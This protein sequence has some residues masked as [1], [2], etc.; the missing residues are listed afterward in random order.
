MPREYRAGKRATATADTRARILDVARALLP[1]AEDI[2][3][4]TIASRAEVSVQTLYTHF[5]SKRGLLI[6][7]IDSVQRDVGL[8]A[9]FERI[10]ASPD[11]ETA[12]RRMVEATVALWHGAWPLVRFS[13]RARRSD[14]EIG[15]YLREVDGYRRSN[16]RSISDRLATERRLHQGLDAEAAADLAF[17][18]SL[19]AIY[20]QLVEF[21]GWPV[22]RATRHVVD[23]VVSAVIDTTTVRV[24]HPPADWSEVARPSATTGL[25]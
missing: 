3:V 19:P 17:S 22:A 11:G 1:A 2:P 4:D 21:R 18:L 13:E 8:Y 9:D 10:W 12:L 20:E 6:A 25:T 16:L 14:A 15:R 7:V 23:A 24:V 5:G